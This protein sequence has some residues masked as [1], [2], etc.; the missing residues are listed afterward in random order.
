MLKNIFEANAGYRISKKHD[1]WLD[2]GI[3]PS[4]IGFESA[5]GADCPTLTRSI[6]ADNSPYYEAG[7]KISYTTPDAKWY[8]AVMYLNGWQRVG[9]IPGNQIPAWGTQLTFSPTPRFSVN[10]SSYAGTE[11]PDS[12]MQWRLFQNVYA[13][14]NLHPKLNLIL[15]FDLGNQ[16]KFKGASAWHVWY[17][18]VVVVQYVPSERWRLAWR[19]EGYSDKGNV[20]VQTPVSEGF[21]TAGY[22]FNVDFLPVRKL[23]LRAEARALHAQRSVFQKNGK[24]SAQ[25]YF[26]TAAV[27][28]SF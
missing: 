11:G 7:V 15:G 4:H 20:M 26:F 21:R 12:L 19:G 16:Q 3:M 17:S 14:W 22:S 27:C 23:L 25:N 5:V 24:P 28:F 2:A 9:R 18:P 6:L 10:W 8:A 13:K 1:L